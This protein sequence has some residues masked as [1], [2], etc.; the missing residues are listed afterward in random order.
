MLKELVRRGEAAGPRPDR[1]GGRLVDRVGPRRP[2]AC[3]ARPPVPA[4]EVADPFGGPLEGYR[5]T[6]AELASLVDRLAA[7]LC[8]DA[9]ARPR[10]PAPVPELELPPT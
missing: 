6:A 8:P 10:P 5:E 9:P 4:D 2:D 1:A 3:R 7:L